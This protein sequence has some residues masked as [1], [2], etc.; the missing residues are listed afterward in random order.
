VQGIAVS[1]ESETQAQRDT[2][3]DNEQWMQA[4][5]DRL[6]TVFASGRFPMIASLA[7][8]PDV[9][10]TLDATFE[11]GLALI[12]DGLTAFIERSRTRAG[13]TPVR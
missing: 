7:H 2:G 6:E 3:I 9:D 4:Q 13:D 11:F 5:G 8:Q 1:L 10:F 12:L